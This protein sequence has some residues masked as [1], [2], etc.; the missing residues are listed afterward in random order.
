M[1]SLWKTNNKGLKISK[2]LFLRPYFKEGGGMKSEFIEVAVAEYLDTRQNLVVPNAWWGLGFSYEL[3]LFVM[4]RSGFGWEIE[5]KTSKSDLVKDKEKRK[6]KNYY[7]G[8]IKRLYFAMPDDMESCLEHVPEKAGI[9]LVSDK[10][11]VHKT[12]EAKNISN[13][14]FTEKDRLKAMHL[15]CMR[16]WKLKQR[17]QNLQK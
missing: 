13:H 16:V 9:L 5:I 7:K 12:R 1:S 3:D 15:C 4:T 8:R 2:I 17:L 10:G 6:W 11:S 14:R